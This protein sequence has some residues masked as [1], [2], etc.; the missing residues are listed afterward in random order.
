MAPSVRSK[1]GVEVPQIIVTALT[2]DARS[3]GEVM[4]RERVNLTDFESEHFTA[5]LLERIRWAVGDSHVAED[6]DAVE[7]YASRPDAE[8]DL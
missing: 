3:V 4:L 7:P 6:E 8:D 1:G 5:Q 2:P